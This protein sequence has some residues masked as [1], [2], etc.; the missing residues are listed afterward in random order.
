MNNR[1]IPLSAALGMSVLLTACVSAPE[2]ESVS[3]ARSTYQAIN[4]DPNVAR[5]GAADLRAAKEHLER[6]EELVEDGADEELIK[7]EAYLAQRHAE[8]AAT[9]GERSAIQKEIEASESRREQLRLERRTAEARRAQNEAQLAGQEAQELRRQLQ[10]LKDMQAQQT[11]RGMVLTLGDVL[12]DLNQATLQA[13][14]EPTITNLAD[15]LS[16][17]E[18]RRVRVEGYTDSTGSEA[19]NQQL[20]EQRAR[21]VQEALM[22]QG[23]SQDRI[24]TKG[25]GEAYPVAS[26]EDASGRARNRRVEI[27]ISDESGNIQ[28]R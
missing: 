27:V 16:K 3:E 26:N 12:F 17:Y 1:R 28:S 5:S 21:A 14:A 22:G 15:F 24:E 25:Y 4:E 7:H 18:D 6:A 23:I 19:Y 10:E 11:D 9:R 20:S 8:I 2:Y 13:S